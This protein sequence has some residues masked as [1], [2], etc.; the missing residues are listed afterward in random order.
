MA[1]E[2]WWDGLLQ[3]WFQP[4]HLKNPI[5]DGQIK[6]V[7]KHQPLVFNGFID[8]RFVQTDAVFFLRDMFLFVQKSLVGGVNPS[9]K[10]EFVNGKDDI[11]YI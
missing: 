1:T 7:P 6:H 11:P 8:V 9:E 5:F 3:R 4:Y 2:P 10:Y